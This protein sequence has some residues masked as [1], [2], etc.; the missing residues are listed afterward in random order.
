MSKLEERMDKNKQRKAE[1]KK[2]KYLHFCFCLP[3][4]KTEKHYSLHT[5]TTPSPTS[6]HQITWSFVTKY[7][8]FTFC[9]KAATFI[10]DY[11]FKKAFIVI[12]MIKTTYNI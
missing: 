12:T 1:L 9:L 7:S 8:V 6:T 10:V 3:K 2:T 5:D 4:T 11:L